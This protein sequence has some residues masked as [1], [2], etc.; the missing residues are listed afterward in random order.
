[1]LTVEER[2]YLQD[3]MIDLLEEYDYSYS[4]DAVETIIN[5][6]LQCKATLIEAFKQHP[7]YVEG[8]FMIAFDTDYEREIDKIAVNDFAHW[9]YR[10]RDVVAPTCKH[11]EMINNGKFVSDIVLF[12]SDIYVLRNRSLDENNVEFINKYLPEMKATIGT[13]TTRMVNKICDYLGYTQLP[14]YNREFAKYADALSPIKIK[15]HTILSVNPLDYLTMSFGNSWASCHTIDKTN[16]RGM[17]NNYSGCYSSGTISYMLDKTSMVLYTVDA[18]YSGDEYWN[19]P[20]INRQMFHYGEDKLV[21]SRLYPQS[22]DSNGEAYTPYRNLVQEIIATIFDFPNLWTIKRGTELMQELVRSLGTHYR[23]YYSFESCVM[24]RRKGIENNKLI[25]VGAEPICIECGCTHSENECINCCNDNSQLY[26]AHCGDAIPEDEAEYINGAYYCHDCCSYC[27][28][29]DEWHLGDEFYIH[30]EQ[31]YVCEYCLGEYYRYCEEC[32]EYEDKDD[33]TWIESIDGYVCNDCLEN[34]FSY[35]DDCGQY[36]RDCL[37]RT[38]N[39]HYV[40][41]ECL[42][43]DY[44]E[45]EVCGEYCPISDKVEDKDICKDCDEQG[46]E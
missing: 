31:R 9:L 10:Y 20:K 46:D 8:K 40:C 24:S 17:P 25:V 23:D 33:C 3:K 37:T 39:G 41:D 18:S 35:C 14:D 36:Y 15:R 42:N 29:C 38:S 5:T 34:H 1:M 16:K 4:C 44:F 6:W 2:E 22:N 32:G 11:D 43:D 19:E 45:C 7:N 28:C 21:Q 13:K 26:C 27:E 30:S 12:I